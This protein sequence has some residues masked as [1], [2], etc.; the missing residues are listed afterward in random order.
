[1]TVKVNYE[2]ANENKNFDEIFEE[3]LKYYNVTDK[4]S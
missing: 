4:K 3:F 2:K 1:M